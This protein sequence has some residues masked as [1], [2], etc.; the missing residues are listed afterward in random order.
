MFKKLLV[1]IVCLFSFLPLSQAQE[2]TT[3][4]NL[5]ADYAILI[6]GYTG[7]VFYEKR[8]DERV[9]PASTTKVLT[10]IVALENSNRKEVV[11]VSKKAA[12]QEGSSCYI[13]EGERYS[14]SDILYGVM[15]PSGNDAA[16][17]LAEHIAG[18]TDNFA[19]LMNS[20]AKLIGAKNSNFV[21]PSGLPD[22]NHY[23]TARD[24]AEIARYAMQHK[25]F[26]EIVG[27]EKVSWPR[28]NSLQP[29]ELRNTNQI[30]GNYFGAT[31][32]KT[33][34]TKAAQRC[35]V[36]SAKRKGMELIAVLYHSPVECWPDARAILDYGFDVI[37]PKTVYKQGE[38]VKTL[39]VY[40]GETDVELTVLEDVVIPIKD[41]FDN[42]KIEI[43]TSK[44]LFA[45]VNVNQE[46]GVLRILY[47]GQEI[48]KVKLYTKNSVAQK[49]EE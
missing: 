33:G 7:R 37:T 19:M 40:K 24:M 44:R 28:Q 16:V 1:L 42:Y 11:V 5:N 13:K 18:T 48:K 8:A 14:Y 41:D 38:I 15:L 27:T 36:V 35:L 25:A 45:P 20:T 49:K 21:N 3:L 17:A 6:D 12:M 32:I 26:R 34:Y 39:P 9:F 2:K 4:P 29:G 31:G 23:T 43:S 47:D 30:I 10:T 22:D 46:A